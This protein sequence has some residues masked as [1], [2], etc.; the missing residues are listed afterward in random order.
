VADLKASESPVS[1]DVEQ[2][3][4][5]PLQVGRHHDDLAADDAGLIGAA[6]LHS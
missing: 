5:Q 3:L 6:V 4:M 2:I 1:T